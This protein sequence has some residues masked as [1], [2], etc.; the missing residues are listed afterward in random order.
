MTRSAPD[1]IRPEVGIFLDLLFLWSKAVRLTAFKDR[2]E[3]LA[4]GIL[5]SLE[6]LPLLPAGAV[7]ILDVGSGGGFPAVPVALAR[8]DT[9]WTLTEPSGRKAAFLREVG[10]VL[11]LDWEVR[12]ETAERA[13]A[14]GIGPFGA[15]TVRGVRLDRRRAGALSAAL[16][17]GG[18]LLLWTGGDV[19]AAYAT[20]LEGAGLRVSS[21]PKESGGPLLLSGVRG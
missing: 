21:S 2:E 3:A 16:V 4:R 11:G 19:A 6:A 14:A 12:E 10:R 20:L 9:R 15:V 7:S 5:P 17:P 18:V 13:L 8:R 1:A